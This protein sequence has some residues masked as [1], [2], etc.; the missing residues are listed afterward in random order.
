M[1]VLVEGAFATS[2]ELL[3]DDV[4]TLL[5]Q[6]A[7]RADAVVSAHRYLLMVRVGPGTPIHLH[8][9]GLD[10][11]EAQRLAADLWRDHPGEDDGSQLVVDIASSRRRYGRLVEF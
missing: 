1:S 5:T 11:G 3:D 9:R 6:I 8:H 2:L 7:A 10:P 4:E